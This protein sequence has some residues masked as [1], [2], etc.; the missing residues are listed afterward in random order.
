[1]RNS[2]MGSWNP[3]HYFP[4]FVGSDI[5][6]VNYF[7]RPIRNDHIDRYTGQ[8]QDEAPINR[9]LDHLVLR[10]RIRTGLRSSHMLF[11]QWDCDTEDTRL[12][13]VP[14][15]QRELDLLRTEQI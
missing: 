10:T 9:H 1:M 11:R 15:L 7:P 13:S 6:F 3:C 12:S 4:V 8:S 5:R 14:G 2:L